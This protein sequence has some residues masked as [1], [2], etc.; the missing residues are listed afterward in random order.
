MAGGGCGGFGCYGGGETEMEVTGLYGAPGKWG[1]GEKN[2]L[3]I[4]LVKDQLE[5]MWGK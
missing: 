2:D 3:K 1:E 4:G 5:C